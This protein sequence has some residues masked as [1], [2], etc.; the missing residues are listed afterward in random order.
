MPQQLAN[1][2]PIRIRTTP[3]RGTVIKM[4]VQEGSE[5]PITRLLHM[6]GWT[7]EEAAHWILVAFRRAGLR[8]AQTVWFTDREFRNQNGTETIA[9][10]QEWWLGDI[11][12]GT[13]SPA[14][15]EQVFASSNRQYTIDLLFLLLGDAWSEEQQ[16]PPSTEAQISTLNN[17]WIREGYKGETKITA[18]NLMTIGTPLLVSYAQLGR[19]TYAPRRTTDPYMNMREDPPRHHPATHP[20]VR[21]WREQTETRRLTHVL[22]VLLEGNTRLRARNHPAGTDRDAMTGLLRRIA[23]E[24]TPADEF[25]DVGYSV[26]PETNHWDG[27][28]YMI[29]WQNLRETEGR[30]STWFLQH[31]IQPLRQ[32]RTDPASATMRELHGHNPIET[33]VDFDNIELHIAPRGRQSTRGRSRSASPGR[34]Q[35]YHQMPQTGNMAAETPDIHE[36]VPRYG[37]GPRF[38]GRG[39]GY[40]FETQKFPLGRGGGTY[41]NATHSNRQETLFPG[42]FRDI[43]NKKAIGAT[44][45]NIKTLAN[46]R[47]THTTAGGTGFHQN[48][49]RQ[50]LQETKSP[51][52]P[53]EDRTTRNTVTDGIET[54]KQKNT[55]RTPPKNNAQVGSQKN[56]PNTHMHE[57]KQR[58]NR[59][60]GSGTNR[61]LFDSTQHMEID[62]TREDG[63]NEA[64]TFLNPYFNQSDT[65]GP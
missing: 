60:A 48:T 6:V 37:Q 64:G 11:L 31:I 30:D 34:R 4:Q 44:K 32:S 17:N 54:T 40:H 15:M 23:H 2:F 5:V 10:P 62:E 57:K 38:G 39:R 35:T 45:P 36:G 20:K 42:A 61:Q 8:Q 22:I 50:P 41:R 18:E 1:T 55:N 16:E 9:I 29:S 3:D 33:E 56:S 13:G 52:K 49:T 19:T 51:I 26:H 43:I 27:A 25:A 7:Q 14:E 21:E 53:T 65:Y 24:I 47:T 59:T 12:I 28:Y 63:D 58:N 46:N